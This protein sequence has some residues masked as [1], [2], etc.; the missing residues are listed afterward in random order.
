MK[1]IL[2]LV[3]ALVMLS[4]L[5]LSASAAGEVYSFA[6]L[7]DFYKYY[8][9]EKNPYE[10]IGDYLSGGIYTWW[11]DT[12]PECG[13]FSYFRV[14]DDCIKYT[15][16]ESECGSS[17]SY[18]IVPDDD[19]TDDDEDKDGIRS[20]QCSDCP[21]TAYYTDKIYEGTKLYYEYEC[22]KGHETYVEAFDFSED[23]DEIQLRPVRCSR[24]TKYAEFDYYYTMDDDLYGV[25]LC[26]K[27]HKTYKMVEEDMFD[28]G[29]ADD[30][31]VRVVTSGNG[32]YEVVGGNYGEYGEYKTVEFT[33][34]RG[35][36]LTNVTVNG[37]TMAI[38]DNEVTFRLYDDTTV[39]AT[40][41][42]Y[43]R[44]I[45]VT[46]TSSG[47]GT[48][49]ATYNNKTVNADEIE[50]Y[51]GDKVTYKFT[52]AS[53]NYYV[54]SI[55][56]NG[57]SVT[58]AKSYTLSNITE[59]TDITVKFSW[60][61]PY[62]DVTSKYAKA[63]EY[64]TEAGIMAATGKSG[65]KL[66]FNGTSTITE[67]AFAAALAEMADTADKLDTVAERIV[68]AEKY[69]IVEEDADLSGTCDVQTAAKMVDKYLDALEAINDIDFDK[70]DDDDSAKKN[71]ISIGLVTEKTYEKN[72]DL[73]RYD[74]A[75][76]C[77]LIATLEYDD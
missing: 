44:N 37:Y 15:C 23:W 60:K 14:D 56:V 39:R 67:K 9:S 47:N 28:F 33:P 65:T 49:K 61:N 75:S 55:K 17:G 66:T 24:C 42:P 57:K 71:A 8:N 12:C 63:V 43:T 4:S 40:F 5:A 72:R 74:L 54:S 13:G 11:Y 30:L 36:V 26:E 52:P 77:R 70:Y 58:A 21:R 32:T 51:Y 68:W 16:L 46:A 73:C 7:I 1:K 62:A 19:K 27:N 76:V 2:S 41:A 29:E 35:Y 50:V 48:I 38:D 31:R 20:V 34:A 18:D 3:L 45:T 59:D 22:S 69:G 64:V 25:Y 10:G 6:D 53:D